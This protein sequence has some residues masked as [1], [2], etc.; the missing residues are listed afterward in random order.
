MQEKSFKTMK[1]ESLHLEDKVGEPQ[2]K[3]SCLKN[4]QLLKQ[5]CE[6]PTPPCTSSK[7][8][9]SKLSLMEILALKDTPSNGYKKGEKRRGRRR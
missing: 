9:G 7:L 3:G 5:G 6:N 8:Q 4:D 2:V 1:G